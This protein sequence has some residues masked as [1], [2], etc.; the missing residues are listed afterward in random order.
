MCHM[1]FLYVVQ[2]AHT[3]WPLTHTSYS[4]Q[5]KPRPLSH[6]PPNMHHRTSIL[7]NLSLAV[8]IIDMYHKFVLKNV[9]VSPRRMPCTPWPWR[10][11]RAANR[12]GSCRL[13]AV[14]SSTSQ[15]GRRVI[16]LK[17]IY[18][19]LCSIFVLHYLLHV[20]FTIRVCDFRN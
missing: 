19:F 15:H 7:N 16:R 9:C 17:R 10:K 13:R 3:A 1:P 20:L 6:D 12:G 4:M 8:C 5:H 2:Q 14:L 18:N 11:E